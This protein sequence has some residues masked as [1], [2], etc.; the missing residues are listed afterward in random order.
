MPLLT[1][2]TN[3]ELPPAVRQRTIQHLSKVVAEALA[4][5]E[6]FV[7]ISLQTNP[8]MLFAGHAAPLAYLRLNSIGLPTERT[9]ELSAILSEALSAEIE[10][11]AELSSR[12]EN[13]DLE[14]LQGLMDDLLSKDQIKAILHRRDRILDTWGNGN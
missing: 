12:L 2:E 14:S 7:M 4:K 9:A 1:I 8:D 6:R 11:P 10:V 13:L 3:R 5:N